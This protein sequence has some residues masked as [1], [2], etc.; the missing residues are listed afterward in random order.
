MTT[1]VNYGKNGY[2]D[3]SPHYPRFA[4]LG[5]SGAATIE[6]AANNKAALIEQLAI[7]NDRLQMLDCLDAW[8]QTAPFKMIGDQL[9]HL[10][11][12]I[13]DWAETAP[14]PKQT[15]RELGAPV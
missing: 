10:N 7:L 13:A 9:K 11:R 3:T 12:H 1:T 6:L 8:Q 14:L 2:L 5:H 4:N 15:K